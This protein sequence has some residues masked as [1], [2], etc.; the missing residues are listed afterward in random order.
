[1]LHSGEADILAPPS[2]SPLRGRNTIGSQVGLFRRGTS[3]KTATA[4][5][6]SGRHWLAKHFLSREDVEKGDNQQSVGNMCDAPANHAGSGGCAAS[7]AAAG[8]S[9]ASGPSN[10]VIGNALY[11]HAIYRVAVIRLV[12]FMGRC[13]RPRRHIATRNLLRPSAMLSKAPCKSSTLGELK[14]FDGSEAHSR[15]IF[16]VSKLTPPP[17]TMV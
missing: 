7:I 10:G 13:H 9:I 17:K 8:I 15:I 16:S 1:M 14:Y 11:P 6:L 2:G 3:D 4:R 5:R 12:R